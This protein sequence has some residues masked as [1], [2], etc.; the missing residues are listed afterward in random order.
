MDLGLRGKAALVVA[1]SRGLGKAVALRLAQEGAELAI[2]ARGEAGLAET[3]LD[4]ETRTGQPVLPFPADVTDPEAIRAL[5]AATAARFGRID[6]LVTNAGGPPPGLFLELTSADWEAALELTLMSVVRLCRAV[7][8]MMQERG[9][10]SILAITSV[11]VKQPLP[12][13]VLSNSLRLGVAGLIKTLANELAPLGI[14]ANA[15][16]PGW[17]RT[18]RV[19]ELLLDRAARAG[20]TAEVEA[21]KIQEDIPIGR[22]ATPAEVAAAA[23]FLVSPAASYITGVSLLVDGGLYRGAT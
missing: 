20:T 22:M 6:V 8:P 2:C 18:S 16:C 17:T 7:I 14:R 10:G 11:S 12:N 3:A 15:I 19:E 9:T 4:I 21:A 23:A 13:L 5:V 1:A